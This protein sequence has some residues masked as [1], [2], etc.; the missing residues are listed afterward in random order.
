MLQIGKYKHGVRSME[1]IIGMSLL[2]GR[3]K[4]ERS[5]LPATTQLELHVDAQAFQNLVQRVELNVD[6]E[7][8]ELMAEEAH[9]VF[10]DD[11][12]ARGYKWGPRTDDEKKEHSSLKNYA[13][14]PEDEKEQNRGNVRDIPQKLQ[15]CGLIVIPARGN[16]EAVDFSQYIEELA[17]MEHNR[18]V[19]AKL[20][21]GWRWAAETDKS[22]KLHKD[23][24][25]WNGKPPDEES[26]H[27]FT[28]A[29]LA[30]LGDEAVPDEEKEKDRVLVRG[31]PRILAKG[32]FTIAR[33]SEAGE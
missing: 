9:E 25:L 1:S 23:L 28:E 8:L 10:C 27:F 19:K 11:L 16:D 33:Y 3:S 15:Q 21:A 7:K 17:E 32:G 2:K 31:I 5:C 29:E 18:W 6:K 20:A 12:R 26:L 13:E 24:L 14:L 4:Y 30:A 22:N